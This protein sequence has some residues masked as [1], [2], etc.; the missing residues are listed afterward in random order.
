VKTAAL[1]PGQATDIGDAVQ[2]WRETSPHVAQLMELASDVLGAG[3]AG[4]T[5]PAALARTCVFQPVL[6]AL[7]IGI[8]RAL[9][10]AGVSP[11]FVAGHSVGEIAAAAAAGAI[12]D[13]DAVCLAAIRG[14]LMEREAAK[15]GGGM[16]AVRGTR[17]DIDAALAM[18][19]AQGQV[20]LAAQNAAD[21]WALSGDAT[22]LRAIAATMQ[23]AP[24]D[25]PGPWHS[26]AMADAVEPY[27]TA[28][29]EAI[30]GAISTPIVCNRTGRVE[31]GSG[32]VLV[33]RLAAQLTS[34]VQW[35]QAMHTLRD[36]GVTRIVVCG[37]GK[38]LRRFARS[39]MPDATVS[40]VAD[41]SDLPRGAAAIP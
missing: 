41:P 37:P 40:V 5:R 33:E 31:Q 32:S 20:C 13:E 28:L 12:T 38:S 25:T 10:E 19:S 8:H 15:H 27:R 3:V 18:G 4:L 29:S 2:A 1:F 16:I 35:L 21:E 36:L 23:A 26:P 11:D 39:V 9:V 24:L 17:S 22:A 14:E 30:R 6:T 7:T 34:P